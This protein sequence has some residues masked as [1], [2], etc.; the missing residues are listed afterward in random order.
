M[1]QTGSGV[2]HV[3]AWGQCPQGTAK[4][5]RNVTVQME[6]LVRTPVCLTHVESEV[7]V[8]WLH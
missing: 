4:R 2:Y 7:H 1:L 3:V 5:L 8:F 6:L